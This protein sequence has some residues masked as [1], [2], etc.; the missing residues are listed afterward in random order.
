M[1]LNKEMNEFMD[2]LKIIIPPRPPKDVNLGKIKIW[3][4]PHPLVTLS[5]FTECTWLQGDA[6]DRKS[7]QITENFKLLIRSPGLCFSLFSLV[8]HIGGGPSMFVE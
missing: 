1:F 5:T 2:A 3:I 6:N 4:S 8:G 7:P